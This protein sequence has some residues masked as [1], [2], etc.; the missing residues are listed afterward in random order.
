MRSNYLVR[1]TGICA[2]IA[3]KLM[4]DA[5]REEKTSG[6]LRIVSRGGE[7]PQAYRGNFAPSRQPSV[8][9]DNA[10]QAWSGDEA[11][12]ADFDGAAMEEPVSEET[13]DVFRF[14]EFVKDLDSLRRRMLG[15][16]FCDHVWDVSR[17]IADGTENSDQLGPERTSDSEQAMRSVRDAITSAVLLLPYHGADARR[18][19]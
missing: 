5:P 1:I 7:N 3:T 13:T 2:D 18:A 12:H 8:V 19:R 10:Q 11:R 15:V 4:V 16:S 14:T 9:R 17:E 6:Q